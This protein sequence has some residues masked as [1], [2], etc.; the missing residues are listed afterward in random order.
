MAKGWRKIRHWVYPVKF[1]YE[2][3]WPLPFLFSM[4]CISSKYLQKL[5]KP[6]PDRQGFGLDLLV[7]FYIL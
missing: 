4:F 5:R 2:G 6:L 1:F 3:G 7:C